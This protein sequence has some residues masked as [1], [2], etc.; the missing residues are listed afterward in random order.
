MSH[1]R[2][3]SYLQ[4]IDEN[5]DLN[6]RREDAEK[7]AEIMIVTDL[8]GTLLDHAT[9]S[10][11]AARPALEAVRQAGLPL[12]LASSKTAAE[13]ATL[14][15]TLG[16]GD[17]P[18]IVENGAGIYRPGSAQ[19]STGTYER[20]RACLNDLPSHL[21]AQY[22]GF[23]DLSAAEVA[24]LTGLSEA[25]AGLAKARHFSEP[26]T[27]RGSAA[28]LATFKTHLSAHGFTAQQ[29]GRFLTL[30][31]GRS[32]ADAM[33]EL[34]QELGAEQVIALGDA[35]ND[36]AMLEA[37][38]IGIIVANPH[39]TP[40]PPLQGEAVGRIRRTKEPGPAGWN[41]AVLDVLKE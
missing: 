23:G 26:G 8:D 39:G 38:D 37:A 35:P 36:R 1:F 17:T 5:A 20:I 30:S 6:K 31:E 12:I 40:L 9:Y 14:S 28:E 15:A 2:K 25:A 29:G 34:A 21:R 3:S 32:K 13:V 16:L 10:F 11:D 19:E 18:A 22:I 33:R 41:A 4:Y 24:A 7:M 27:W